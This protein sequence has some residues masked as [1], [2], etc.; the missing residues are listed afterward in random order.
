MK[1]MIN[2]INQY[3]NFKQLGAKEE[4]DYLKEKIDNLNNIKDT[5]E[6]IKEFKWCADMCNTF[7]NEIDYDFKKHIIS[8]EIK[9]EEEDNI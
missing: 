9:K 7:Y 6:L 1:R 3:N 5:Q 8:E 2:I 4:I